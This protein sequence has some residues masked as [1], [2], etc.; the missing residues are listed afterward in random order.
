MTA[1]PRLSLEHRSRL[2]IVVLAA[3]AAFLLFASTAF[4]G[5]YGYYHAFQYNESYGS[6]YST[7]W[8]INSFYADLSGYSKTVTWINNVDYGWSGTVTNTSVD[9]K[10]T[11]STGSP[12]V[13]AHCHSNSFSPFY[14]WCNVG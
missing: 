14:G 3:F 9:T 10:T 11:R 6:G 1:S 8:V 5:V 4:A 7:G 2:A 12:A 13:K